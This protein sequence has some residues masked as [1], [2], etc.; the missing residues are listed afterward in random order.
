MTWYGN[1]AYQPVPKGDAASDGVAVLDVRTPAIPSSSASSARP[2]WAGRGG[3]LGIHEGIHVSQERGILA[4]PD[5]HAAHRLRH[6][7][8][9]P[10]A[11]GS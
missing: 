11:P 7:P 10:P 6:L 9:L 3:V 4:V 2:A 1:C 5:R 8:R